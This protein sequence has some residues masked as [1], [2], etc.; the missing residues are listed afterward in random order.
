M[1]DKGQEGRGLERKGIMIRRKSMTRE[2][3]LAVA[4]CVLLALFL[5]WA[6]SGGSSSALIHRDT[7]RRSWSGSRVWKEGEKKPEEEKKFYSLLLASPHDSL[8]FLPKRSIPLPHHD[9]DVKIGQSD[10][11][12]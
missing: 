12:R 6:G 10:A 11:I 4:G 7:P 9:E 1:G 5:A 3:G 2:V 8:V